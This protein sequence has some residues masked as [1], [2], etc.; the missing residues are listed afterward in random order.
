[1]CIRGRI[2]IEDVFEPAA[3]YRVALAPGHC[4]GD[5]SARTVPRIM[6]AALALNRH[7]RTRDTEEIGQIVIRFAQ[8]KLEEAA[9]AGWLRG[10]G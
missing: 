5:C 1:M 3:A 7:Q 2:L 6:G 8:G 10:G 4:F 9:L